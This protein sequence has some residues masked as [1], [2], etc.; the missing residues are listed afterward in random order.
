MYVL[1]EKTKERMYRFSLFLLLRWRRRPTERFEYGAEKGERSRPTPPWRPFLLL[2]SLSHSVPLVPHLNN[3]LCRGGERGGGGGRRLDDGGRRRR[4]KQPR[5]RRRRRRPKTPSG[6]NKSR[7]EAT[8]G[9][10]KADGCH[11]T[12]RFRSPLSSPAGTPSMSNHRTTTYRACS[13]YMCKLDFAKKKTYR[14][15]CLDVK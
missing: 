11:S 5:R 14:Q 15:A 13:S 10:A 7:G 2:P 4:R 1:C 3:H 9:E 12:T 6:N 8:E